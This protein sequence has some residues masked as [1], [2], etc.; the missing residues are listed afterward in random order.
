MAVYN[1][2]FPSYTWP[3]KGIDFAYLSGISAQ[4]AQ[5]MVAD[6][7]SFVGRYLF[8]SQYPNGKGISRQEAEFYLNAGL[9]IFLYYEVN[10]GDAL[11]GYN[12]GV[13]NGQNA[14]A[15]ATDLGVPQGTPIICC[16]DTSVT[17]QQA[18]GVV[19]QYLEGF[20]SEILGYNSGI[21]GGLNVVEACY[22][23]HPGL[24]RVQAGAWGSQ[25]FS[26]IDV[27]QW[28]IPRNIDAQNDGYV[29]ISNVTIDANGYASWRGHSVD[30]ISAPSLQ[31]MWNGQPAPQPKSKM[32]I[33]FY[34][35]K[36]R[37]IF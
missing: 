3:Y 31:Y 11:G 12:A 23:A 13:A 14:Y 17:D 20:T 2:P 25:E 27:R 18:S 7:I 19:L 6:G 28:Y 9:A 10:A 37:G 35:K 21:Y 33:W 24:W 15:L 1:Y 8:S 30:L 22:N 26:D 34:L 4:L 16:C 29:S 36:N 5:D 32:P